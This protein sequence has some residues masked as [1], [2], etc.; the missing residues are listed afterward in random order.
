MNCMCSGTLKDTLVEKVGG[1]GS[2]YWNFNC[3]NGKV[4][5]IWMA[6]EQSCSLETLHLL[7]HLHKRADNVLQ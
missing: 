1:K 3:L 4:I 2:V 5:L 6:A 7:G